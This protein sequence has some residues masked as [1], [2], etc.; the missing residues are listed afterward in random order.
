MFYLPLMQGFA[1]ELFSNL[2]FVPFCGVFVVHPPSLSRFRFFFFSYVCRNSIKRLSSCRLF[3]GFECRWFGFCSCP[4]PF[5]DTLSGKV[6]FA[7]LPC[8]SLRHALNRFAFFAPCSLLNSPFL[9]YNCPLFCSA[10]SV[11]FSLSECLNSFAPLFLYRQGRL[12]F[13]RAES[14]RFRC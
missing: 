10:V 1:F 12:I 7:R 11:S 5:V 2:F 3:S 14:R 13:F 4:P 9:H 8:R 6:S